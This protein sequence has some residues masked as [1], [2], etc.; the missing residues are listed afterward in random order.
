MRL[1]LLLFASLLPVLAQIT[2]PPSGSSVCT[3]SGTQTTGYVLTATNGTNGCSWQTV[4]GATVDANTI[5]N[6]W[7]IADSGSANAITGTTTTA[8]PS[9]YSAGQVVVVKAAAT[10]T[11]ATTININSLGLKNVTKNGATALAAGNIVS[12]QDYILAYDG[13]QF[14]CLNFTLLA[15]DLPSITAGSLIQKGNGTGGLTAAG[16]AD[17][18]S[19]FTGCSGT[20][21]PGF[22][23]ACHSA[24]GGGGTPGG[25]SGQIQWNSA[26]SFAGFT[27]SGDCTVVTSTGAITCTKTNGT[28]FASS[29]TVDATNANNIS[30][31]TLGA[32]R[33]PAFTGDMTT[34][35]GTVATTVV[36]VNGNTPGGS[37]TNQAVTSVSTSAVPTCS[38][39]TSAYVDT[40]IAKTGTDINTSNQVTATHLAS[41]LPRAQGG[42]NSTS[43][44]TGILR[45]GTTPTASE[46]SGDATT[47]GSNAV[48][49][50]GI[51]GTALSG[52]ATGLIK[53]TT[54][55]GAI[56]IA[57][58]AD[59]LAACTGCLT[60]TPTNHGVALGSSTQAAGYTS[61]GT[62]GQVLTSNGASA[63]PTFQAV[64]GAMTQIAQT[65]L[66]S[67]ASSVTFSSIPGT[68]NELRLVGTGASS[69]SATTDDVYI[70]FNGD[71]ATH[72]ANTFIYTYGGSG[73][74]LTSTQT[75]VAQPDAG[76]ISGST[77]FR[78]GGTFSVSIPQ[79][80]NTT[81]AKYATTA[82]AGAENST[83][84]LVGR[85]G[86]LL[87]TQTTAITSIGIHL[88][89]ASA[90]FV[91][92]SVFTLYGVN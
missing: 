26:G 79:Y 84:Q 77:A 44:G 60:G 15:A 88:Y 8:F 45:D 25:T 20:Q 64:A 29:A 70:Q 37:C 46:L 58:Q 7:Y 2:P 17:I 81:F 56:S 59:V 10:N 1:P 65:V 76:Q 87:W 13:T 66:S 3:V 49:V 4:G 55:T 40:S 73:S 24:S 50:K 28:A 78:Q 74:A 82:G 68:Y 39:I 53:N 41:G 52:L 63:D 91:A 57:A 32:A 35:A 21:Y 43:A 36:K 31:G 33:F 72:Y 75:N 80:A 11:G 6:A 61:A 51:N 38:T 30:A 34:T 16:Y 89:C 27:M 19:L 69:C 47:S 92:G 22:D 5:R 85:T 67:P 54:A 23:G 18:F 86:S 83:R 90:N 14:E 48:T 12:G 9:S 71:T 62:A 42:L